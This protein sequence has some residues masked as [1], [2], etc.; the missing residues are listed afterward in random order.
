MYP[1]SIT[2]ASC[3]FYKHPIADNIFYNVGK[4][5]Q[6]A[7]Q[8]VDYVCTL[9]NR[10]TGVYTIMIYFLGLVH[11]CYLTATSA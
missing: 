9:H 6:H 10:L 11:N 1:L 2:I 8:S 7:R 4:Y 5:V 3:I